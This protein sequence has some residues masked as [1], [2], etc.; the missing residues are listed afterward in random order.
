[1][2]TLPLEGKWTHGKV[3]MWKFKFMKGK[4]VGK[5]LMIAEDL[6]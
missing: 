3:R 5:E 4:G 1:M 2:E 6:L